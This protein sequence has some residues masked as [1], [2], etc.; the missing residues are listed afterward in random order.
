MET[1][2]G[3]KQLTIEVPSEALGGLDANTLC[4]MGL[5]VSL[6]DAVTELLKD[7][8]ANLGQK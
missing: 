5:G 7:A 8:R 1:E 4:L 2:P 6:Q 3:S